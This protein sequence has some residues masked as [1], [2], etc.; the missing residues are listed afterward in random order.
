[1]RKEI[2]NSF[3]NRKLLLIISSIFIL[4]MVYFFS[5]SKNLFLKSYSTVVFDAK[6][7]LLGARVSDDGKWRFPP[8]SCVPFKLEKC[9]LEFED[10]HFYKH[11]GFNPVSLCKAAKTNI[12]A[13]KKIRGGSTISMQVIRLSRNGKSRTYFEKM[14]EIILATRLEIRYSKKEI[15]NL[16][17]NHAPY[18]K[19][20][21]GVNAA[22]WKYFNR[23][24]SELSWAEAALLAVLPNAPSMM[25]LAKNR[26]K[27]VLKRN[28]L[29]YRLCA[30]KIIDSETLR[31]ALAEPLPVKPIELPDIAPHL[32]EN[33]ISTGHKGQKSIVTID[34]AFQQNV[35]R[36]VADYFSQLELNKISNAAV[37]VIEVNSGKV[38]AYVG[39]IPKDLRQTTE[40]D[41]DMIQ[42][43]R[44]TGSILKPL[45]YAAS[46]QDGLI[47]PTTLIADLPVREA[48]FRPENYE[49]TYDGAVP[50]NRALSRSLNIPAIRLLSNYGI[51]KFK[52]VLEDMGMTTLIYPADHYGLTLIVGGA[53]CKLWEIT[54]IYAT[55]A[56]TLNYFSVNSSYHANL[57]HMPWYRV[58]E[59]PVK[60]KQVLDAGAVWLTFKALL[61]VNRPDEERSL[62]ALS[63]ASKIAWKTGTSYGF[64]DGWAI[65]TTPNYVVGVWTGNADGEG[66]PGLTGIGS[67]APLMFRVLNLLTD[68]SW[69]LTPYDDLKVER[70]CHTSGYKAGQYCTE[71]DSIL[72]CEQ[73][74]RTTLCPYHILV[75]L[76]KQRKYRVNS[77]CYNPDNM[78]H[79]SWF[80]LPPAMEWF[81]K[82]KDFFYK[83]LPPLKPGCDNDA[84]IQMIDLIYPNELLKIY[85]PRE[86]DGSPG[87]TIFEAAHRLSNV[88]LFWHL[89]EDF[90]AQTKT[91]HQVA[92]N[93][94]PGR[95]LLTIVDN[96]GNTFSRWF[97]VVTKEK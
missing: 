71:T 24:S 45:L 72:T 48:G 91:F 84:K 64:R 37:L 76:D 6:G 56:R 60:T 92:L 19:N 13:G 79:V 89:D 34:I 22:A 62:A 31:L 30:G 97:E 25:H 81:Y 65:G 68:N 18:G 70:I 23:N 61:D 35:N 77:L 27:I 67:A 16:Y 53:E 90:L 86:I 9:I 82:K 44:S 87:K 41:V 52:N 94:T 55:M 51:S 50:A 47:M 93:P 12:E 28:R 5:L 63:N 1:L 29:L 85:V 38:I 95:H 32:T 21:E 75:H 2:F 17:A 74:S 36:I 3:K 4:F 42:A 49:K 58:G 78:V 15:L 46:Q 20:V 73:G 8:D 57:Y 26:E 69:F 10:R 39:N 66:R 11:L 33:I 88:T 83:P 43:R 54:G 40:Q 96:Y 59:K 80:V 7:N 14:I